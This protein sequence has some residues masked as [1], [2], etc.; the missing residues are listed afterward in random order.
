M[1]ENITLHFVLTYI[2]P[3]IAA[4]LFILVVLAIKKIRVNLFINFPMVS[5]REVRW[6]LYQTLMA[7]A[8]FIFGVAFTVLT[9]ALSDV[10]GAVML[11]IAIF[12]LVVAVAATI[13]VLLLGNHYYNFPSS[14]DGEIILIVKKNSLEYFTETKLENNRTIVITDKYRIEISNLTKEGERNVTNNNPDM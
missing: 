4:T 1:L 2:I 11:G 14:K 9:I 3:V 6:G 10:G 13:Y 7:W 12:L 5:L 8:F